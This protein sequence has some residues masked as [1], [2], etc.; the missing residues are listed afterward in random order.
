VVVPCDLRIQKRES[1]VHVA[2]HRS[3]KPGELVTLVIENCWQ[4]LP[5]LQRR[6]GDD[7]ALLGQ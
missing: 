3:G 7:Y 1:F 5:Y 6:L 4:L 2:H